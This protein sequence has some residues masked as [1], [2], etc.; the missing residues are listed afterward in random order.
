LKQSVGGADVDFTQG[1]PS[2]R[3]LPSTEPAPD[4]QQ[5]RL[6]RSLHSRGD[7]RQ[8]TLHSP[9]PA[10]VPAWSDVADEPRVFT[11]PFGHCIFHPNL[12]VRLGESDLSASDASELDAHANLLML[13]SQTDFRTTLATGTADIIRQHILNLSP[14][15]RPV[16]RLYPL[17][18][19][20]DLSVSVTPIRAALKLLAAEGLVEFS[21]RRGAS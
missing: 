6:A 13:N 19:A 1:E 9:R 10:K 3:L 5:R 17:K 20:Q 15:F 12:E 21:P 14:G 8:T 11:W 7:P 18:L 16:D 2:A 4:G